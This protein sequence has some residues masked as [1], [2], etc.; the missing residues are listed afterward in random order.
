MTF[1]YILKKCEEL[2]VPMT[3]K[4]AKGIVRKYGKRKDYL[5]S[6]DCAAVI[7]R[8]YANANNRRGNAPNTNNTPKK[9]RVGAPVGKR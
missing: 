9:S 8:R 7:N 5:T 3:Q 2:G 1:D 6:D 4:V